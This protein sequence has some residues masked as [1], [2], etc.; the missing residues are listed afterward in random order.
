MGRQEVFEVLKNN[1]IWMS[2]KDIQEILP[3][4]TNSINRVANNLVYD[5]PNKIKKKKI[6]VGLYNSFR[7]KY[8]G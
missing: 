7:Y 2:N 4:S 1:K 3:Q 8:V 5:F 6:R